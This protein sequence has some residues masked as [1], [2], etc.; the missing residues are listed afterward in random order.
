M[1]VETA[2]SSS[3]VRM[4]NGGTSS[5]SDVKVDADARVGAPTGN[6][7]WTQVPFP[8]SLEMSISPS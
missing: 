6:F 3:I 5:G 2:A 7:N 1:T 4:R 8:G